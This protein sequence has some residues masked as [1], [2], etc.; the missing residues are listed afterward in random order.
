MSFGQGVAVTPLQLVRFYGALANDGVE[1]TPHFLV[2]KPQTGEVP[3]YDT[4]DVIENKAAI[5]TIT[6]MLK[7]VVTDGT[8]KNAQIEG[9]SVAGKTSTAE[10]AEERRVP[11]RGLQPVFE[12]FLPGPTSQLVCF[13]GLNEVPSQGNVS[14]VFKDIMAFAIDRYKIQPE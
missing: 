4:E 3:T 13:V 6:D 10:I 7:T 11:S 9:Y 5:P 1:V 8:G 14:N 2:S 12:D